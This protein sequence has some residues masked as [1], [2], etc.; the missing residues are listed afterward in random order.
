[1]SD[2]KFAQ[3]PEA[4]ISEQLRSNSTLTELGA[5]NKDNAAVLA[6]ALSS[7]DKGN[8]SLPSLTIEDKSL[9]VVG[10]PTNSPQYFGTIPEITAF[11]GAL[12]FSK[13]Q[14]LG[15]ALMVGAGGYQGYKDFQYL[16]QS[17]T[18]LQ[19]S[20]FTGALLTDASMV[21]GGILTVAKVGPK[22]LA[23]TLMIGGF[24]GRALLDLVPDR[25]GSVCR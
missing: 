16:T 6:A 9:K 21:T 14:Y 11:T 24:A 2:V 3:K 19:R 13:N 22:W 10:E 15:A 4:T 18:L 1:M 17:E 8:S 25:L 5:Y 7:A 23:P 20:K 12:A